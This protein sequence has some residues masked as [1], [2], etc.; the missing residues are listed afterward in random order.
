MTW[1]DPAM[2]EQ[3]DALM[4]VSYPEPTPA[5]ADALDK[6]MN[7]ATFEEREAGRAALSLPDEEDEDDY[8]RQADDPDWGRQP[9]PE[10]ARVEAE[11]EAWDR[12]PVAGGEPEAQGYQGDSAEY[13]ADHE[14]DRGAMND[15]RSVALD[16]VA[17]PEPQIE[18][19]VE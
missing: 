10:L 13:A 15:P 1:R 2:Q 18:S 14:P 8:G 16:V 11:D 3:L 5:E 9:D 12:A 7:G 4:R 17:T 19:E 6:I